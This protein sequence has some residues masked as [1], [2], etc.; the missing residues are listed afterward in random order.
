MQNEHYD[1]AVGA[2][3]HSDVV[4]VLEDDLGVDRWQVP[5]RFGRVAK[6]VALVGYEDLGH[7]EARRATVDAAQ[8]VN[9]FKRA[10]RALGAWAAHEAAG[11]AA[12]VVLGGGVG[13]EQQRGIAGGLAEG[14]CRS[15]P[16]RLRRPP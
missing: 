11:Q 5:A 1:S 13:L 3:P 14:R 8:L 7:V 6:P 10:R 15:G 16:R 4:E 2:Y 12:E 9:S